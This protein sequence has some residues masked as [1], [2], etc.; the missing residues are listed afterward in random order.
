MSCVLSRGNFVRAGA[1]G[2]PVGLYEFGG[3]RRE[4]SLV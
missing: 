3:R 4:D 1:G 2:L